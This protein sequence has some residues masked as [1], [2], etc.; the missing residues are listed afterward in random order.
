MSFHDLVLPTFSDKKL[1]INKVLFLLSI[2]PFF[3][4]YWLLLRFSFFFLIIVQVQLSPFSPHHAPCPTH[5]RLPPWNLPPLSSSMYPLYMFPDGTSPL[6]P[7]YPSPLSFLV[8]VSLFF[9]FSVSGYIL[10]ACLFC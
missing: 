6:F 9:Y 3:S 2:V 10:L 4:C 8:T 1:V 5:P 7:H